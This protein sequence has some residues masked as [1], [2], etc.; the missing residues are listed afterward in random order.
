MATAIFAQA[1]GRKNSGTCDITGKK[2]NIK[3]GWEERRG[4]VAVVIVVQTSVCVIK[5]L[6]AF[7]SLSCRHGPTFCFS[8][9]APGPLEGMEEGSPC[10]K[11]KVPGLS[12]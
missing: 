7:E 1:G 2:A 8:H 10:L 3:G 9:F 6:E 11:M 12:G 4:L 5:L